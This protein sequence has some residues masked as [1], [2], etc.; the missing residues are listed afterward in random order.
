M[1][2]YIS[3]DLTVQERKNA[4]ELRKESKKWG[5]SRVDQQERAGSGETVAAT[6]TKK[7]SSKEKIKAQN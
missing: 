7:N 6:K 2:I 4:L 1:H 5:W 3:P